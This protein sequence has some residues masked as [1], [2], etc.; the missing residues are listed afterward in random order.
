[1]QGRLEGRV[2]Y[3]DI[4]ASI[5]NKFAV[6][7]SGGFLGLSR[8]CRRGG[9]A[10]ERNCPNLCPGVEQVS[11]IWTAFLGA[12]LLNSVYC[13]VNKLAFLN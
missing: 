11:R 5:P 7:L 3:A 9:V 13:H 10:E 6:V 4:L 2:R 8:S 12:E 1:L